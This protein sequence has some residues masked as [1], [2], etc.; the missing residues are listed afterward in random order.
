MLAFIEQYCYD[1]VIIFLFGVKMAENEITRPTIQVTPAGAE[2]WP[3]LERLF[4]AHGA[5]SNCW[6]MFWRLAH[7]DFNRMTGEERKAGL[8]SLA[9]SAQP[10]GLLAYVDGTVAGWCSLG[11]REDF[12]AL[13]RSRTLKRI[14]DRPVWSVVCFFIAKPYR[15]QG[16]T[17]A[18]LKGAVDYAASQGAKI[19]E[20]YPIDLQTPRLQ[21]ARLTGC[22]GY[23]GI[24]SVFG[25]VGFS[26]AAR[27]SET[28]VI[29]R[30]FVPEPG[31]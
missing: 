10:P 24:A 30:Y 25:A 14:D 31:G 20:A 9:L 13:E 15:R 19:I 3:D 28:Q 7:T 18:L 16:I 11:R 5:Y 23:M 4:G 2:R 29:M 26:E 17:Q 12:A 27:A 21:D 8:Q 6:C 1:I 22:S